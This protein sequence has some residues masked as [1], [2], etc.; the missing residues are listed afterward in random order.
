MVHLVTYSL[1]FFLMI[2]QLK[3]APNHSVE[4][5]CSVPKHQK[6]VMCLGRKYMC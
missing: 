4:V 1:Y 3:M 2:L 6:A 5:L